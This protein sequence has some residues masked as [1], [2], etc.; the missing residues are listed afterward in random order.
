MKR[1]QNIQILRVLAC[2]GVF[3]THLAP[4][5]GMQGMAARIAN[6]GASGVYLFFVISGFLACHPTA[7]GGRPVAGQPSAAQPNGGGVRWKTL[8]A[9]YIKRAMKILPLYYAV[10]VYNI[11]LHTFIL[12][13][14]TPDP[15]G[16]CWLRYFFLTNAFIPAP[17]NFWGNLS[18]TWTISLFWV[19]Y[20][21]APFF[22][23]FFQWAARM[24]GSASKR[25]EYAAV[26][27]AVLLYLGT[28]ALRYVWVA[29][30]LSAY[31][32][33]F[34]YLHFFV[35]GMLAKVLAEQ[36]GGPKAGL[37][38]AALG[39]AIWAVLQIADIGNDEFICLSWVFAAVLLLSLDMSW[40]MEKSDGWPARLIDVLD[41]HSYAI[42]LVHAVVIDGILLLQ[43]KLAL[44][45]IA[46]LVIALS[47]TAAGAYL[48]RRLIEK[49]AEKLGRRL[50]SA[51]GM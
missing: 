24:G 18:A 42:Y 11:L 23:T 32:M 26:W 12:Q 6:F 20:L 38:A 30:G 2:L 13:D 48:A 17:D 40:P 3:V 9:Y 43:G 22:N 47:L 4:R 35:L 50:V 39:A 36:F 46:V 14:V 41:E 28:L 21:L 29:A 37:T 7:G 8:I 51:L 10:V 49:P 44:P 15:Q 19:F 1:Y 34:Y 33:V 5:L 27:P 16:L 25:A 45:K 31:M